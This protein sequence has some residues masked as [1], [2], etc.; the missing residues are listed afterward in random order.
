MSL[1][2][3]DALGLVATTLVAPILPRVA[4]AGAPTDKRFVV[5]VRRCTQTLQLGEGEVDRVVATVFSLPAGELAGH[6]THR[7]EMNVM[8]HDGDTIASQHDILLEII[9]PD[10]MGVGLRL[11]GMLGQIPRGSAVSDHDRTGGRHE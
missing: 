8:Q 1:T 3:R 11:E 4:L 7:V 9:R 2:R 6:I 5:V 10:R